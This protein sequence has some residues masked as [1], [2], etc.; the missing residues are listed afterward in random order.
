MK[1]LFF[2]ILS[3]TQVEMSF[4]SLYDLIGLTN[5]SLMNTFQGHQNY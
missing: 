4:S 1:S 5:D 2:D 3:S